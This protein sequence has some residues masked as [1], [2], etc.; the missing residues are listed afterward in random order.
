MSPLN[1]QNLDLPLPHLLAKVRPMDLH[2]NGCRSIQLILVIAS[3]DA[4]CDFPHWLN[5]QV[6]GIHHQLYPVSRLGKIR[7]IKDDSNLPWRNLT[8][9]LFDSFPI[10][11]KFCHS[12]TMIQNSMVSQKHFTNG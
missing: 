7:I 4:L 3:P 12:M 5:T 2:L 9:Q 6:S 10:A 8:V 1:R 11:L